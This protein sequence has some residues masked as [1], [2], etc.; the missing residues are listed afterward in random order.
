VEY[1]KLDMGLA[2]ICCFSFVYLSVFICFW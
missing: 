2:H 1:S